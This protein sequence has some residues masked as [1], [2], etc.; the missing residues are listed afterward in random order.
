MVDAML[1]RASL[2]ILLICCAAM[3]VNAA[4]PESQEFTLFSLLPRTLPHTSRDASGYVGRCPVGIT[5]L[6][7]T[8]LVQRTSSCWRVSK[9]F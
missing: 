5:Y 1:L 3:A 4:G 8:H 9:A 6:T 7:V 2:M